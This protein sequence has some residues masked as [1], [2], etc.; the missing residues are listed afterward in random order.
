MDILAA[1]EGVDCEHLLLCAL[2]ISPGLRGS[3]TSVFEILVSD[4]GILAALCITLVGLMR[5][6]RS[7]IEVMLLD[8]EKLYQTLSRATFLVTALFLVWVTVFDNWR[9]L[10]GE[11]STYTHNEKTGMASDP[12][13]NTPPGDFE[14]SVS[15]IL[16]GL[17]VLGA[18]YLFARY[19]RGYWGP[20][21]ATP[22]ALAMYYVFNAFRVRMDVDS[23]RIAFADIS[24]GLDVIATL[25]WIAGLWI[26]FSLLILCVFM[27]FWGPA[28]IVVSLIYRSTVGKVVYAESDMFRIIR[29][30]SEA[31]RR[32]AEQ[33]PHRQA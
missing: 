8:R 12:F 29:E 7:A 25:F 30:R 11:V 2:A 14:R 3:P 18:A 33:E 24:S 31:R 27:L 5:L 4:W 22:I 23:V 32:A 17:V 28:S 1:D 9:Q 13:A 21:V 20:L 15:Y 6:Y 26:S 16:F 10:L 19:A